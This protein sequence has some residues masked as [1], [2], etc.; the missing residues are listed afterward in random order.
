MVQ[1]EEILRKAYIYAIRSENKTFIASSEWLQNFRKTYKLD[2]VSV[3]KICL[4]SLFLV[5][6]ETRYICIIRYIM[7][8]VFLLLT[9]TFLFII[10]FSDSKATSKGVD[11]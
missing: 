6:T 11:K 7:Y 1:N 9:V 4:H 3:K 10:L 8:L 5:N 2:N